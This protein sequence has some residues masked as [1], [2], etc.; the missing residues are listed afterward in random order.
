MFWLTT[1]FIF[2]ESL[3]MNGSRFSSLFIRTIYESLALKYREVLELLVSLTSMNVER[4][5]VIGGGSQNPMLCQMTAD[6]TGRPVVA[7]PVEA[8]TLGNSIMQLISLGKLDDVSHA[9]E[10]LS[11]TLDTRSYMPNEPE[12]WREPYTRFRSTLKNDE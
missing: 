2:R 3:M 4:I 8:T 7:G 10:V 6:A 12:A 11:Q 9:R 5:H 1:H